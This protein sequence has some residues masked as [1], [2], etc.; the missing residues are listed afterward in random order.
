MEHMKPKSETEPTTTELIPVFAII[1]RGSIQQAAHPDYKGPLPYER[2]EEIL[3]RVGS[4]RLEPD[5][6]YLIQLV[7]FPI[8]GELLLRPVPLKKNV[9]ST[10]EEKQ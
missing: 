2:A 5:G 3:N 8:T 1:Q 10:L 9:S 4:A 7:A 6:S